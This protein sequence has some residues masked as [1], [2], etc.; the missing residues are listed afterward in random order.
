M[1]LSLL[2][3][4]AELMAVI[5]VVHLNLAVSGNRETLCRGLVCLN[6]SQFCISCLN[7]V[8]V[9]GLTERAARAAD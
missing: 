9:F 6:F 4:D 2:I 1:S 7:K 8:L 3:L 5:R